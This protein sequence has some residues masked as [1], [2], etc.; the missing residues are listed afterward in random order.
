MPSPFALLKSV[1]FG[2]WICFAVVNVRT[3]LRGNLV[4]FKLFWGTFNIGASVLQFC[5]LRSVVGIQRSSVGILVKSMRYWHFSGSYRVSVFCER[6]IQLIKPSNF[7]WVNE[8]MNRNFDLAYRTFISNNNGCI[9]LKRLQCLR[10]VLQY[11]NFHFKSSANVIVL[12]ADKAVW[13]YHKYQTTWLLFDQEESYLLYPQH[14]TTT[15]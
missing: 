8:W 1:A 13:G 6:F 5:M 12:F 15:L 7:N 14:S 4:G 2:R 9:K 11:S 10:C 3:R